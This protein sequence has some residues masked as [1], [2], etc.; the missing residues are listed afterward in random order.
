MARQREEF[1]FNPIDVDNDTA[2]GIGLPFSGKS[3][4]FHLNYTTTDQAVSNLKNLILTR[5][6]ERYMQ[7][8]F[9]WS[10]WD[11][12]FD[13]NTPDLID[14]LKISINT[15]IE[16]WLP[17]IIIDQVNIKRKLDGEPGQVGHGITISVN[18]SI[19]PSLANRVITIELSET[20]GVTVQEG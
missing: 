20:G 14:K 12:L 15:D 3:G 7:P 10:G 8:Q 1:R 4:F 17:Y 9:G 13:Q 19:E 2:V 5:K 11:L 18:I 6:G 16:F